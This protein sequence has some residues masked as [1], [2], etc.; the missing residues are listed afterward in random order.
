MRWLE[1]KHPPVPNQVYFFNTHFY[2]ALTGATKSRINHKA[3]E[4][5]TRNVDLF[6]YDFLVIPIHEN[7]HWYL[8]MV[9]N[10]PNLA[11]ILAE[12]ELVEIERPEPVVEPRSA[13]LWKDVSSILNP[14]SEDEDERPTLEKRHLDD[15]QM[16]SDEL[17]Q[18]MSPVTLRDGG[19]F[20]NSRVHSPVGRKKRR[21][22]PRKKFKPDDPMI[23]ILDSLHTPHGQTIQNLKDYLIAEAKSKRS[24]EITRDSIKGANLKH[25]I[26]AQ[27]NFCDCG[28]FVCGY[29]DKFMRDPKQFGRKMLAQE[30]DEQVDWPEMNPSRM[31]RGIKQL[32]QGIAKDQQEERVRAKREKKLAKKAASNRLPALDTSPP[33]PTVPPEPSP[34]A[35]SSA[36]PTSSY[37]VP[38]PSD[39]SPPAASH[40]PPPASGRSPPMASNGREP[41]PTI[42]A[43]RRLG[44][45]RG[46]ER[47]ARS[48]VY[49]ASPSPDHNA[50][51]MAVRPDRAENGAH[52]LGG[53]QVSPREDQR[54]QTASLGPAG[55][56]HTDD[57]EMQDGY[58]S[59]VDILQT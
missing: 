27:D 10:L 23:V 1:E 33:R 18:D 36:P 35:A 42:A 58:D 20:Q 17:Q 41:G 9:C 11:R 55:R 24:M 7:S 37:R 21:V 29:I 31:R 47:H 16:H 22:M 53:G 45:G 14:R 32:L 40:G 26:P 48:R 12:D 50:I 52:P 59:S 8:A 44:S 13:G 34:P 2:T 57:D 3:V 25:G 51:S 38:S 4:R 30:F 6:N 54:S 46:F 56:G 43:P 49:E 39:R 28:L 15:D 19:V 5:W